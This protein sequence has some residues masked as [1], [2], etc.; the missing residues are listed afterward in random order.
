MRTTHQYLSRRYP[1]LDIYAFVSLLAALLSIVQVAAASGKGLPLDQRGATMMSYSALIEA[2]QRFDRKF[3]WV[4]GELR[5]I[6]RTA[7]LGGTSVPHPDRQKS[8]CVK[9]IESFTGSVV[10]PDGSEAQALLRRFDGLGVSVHGRY[11]SAPNPACPNGTV[12]VALL[13]VSFE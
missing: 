1:W 5:F 2:P 11:E 12:F 3:V 8:V 13:E 4:L 9:P 10:D 7:Y 6:D